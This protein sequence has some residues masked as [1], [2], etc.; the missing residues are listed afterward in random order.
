[1]LDG[2]RIAERG[3]HEELMA[4]GGAYRKLVD[5]QALNDK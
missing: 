2:G 5:L 4:Q 3:R 1:V